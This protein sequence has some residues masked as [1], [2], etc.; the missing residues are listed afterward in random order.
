MAALGF[1]VYIIINYGEKVD[2]NISA[3]SNSYEVDN[4]CS[5]EL[6]KFKNNAVSVYGVSNSKV[7]EKTAQLE[8][9]D[10]EQ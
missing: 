2:D 7:R 1:G 4:K 9:E 3:D 6:E 10:F 8:L 5:L